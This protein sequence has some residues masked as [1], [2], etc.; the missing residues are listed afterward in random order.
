MQQ[1][2]SKSIVW[3]NP[4]GM[5]FSFSEP[6]FLSLLVVL[7]A[8]HR[9]L[10]AARGHSLYHRAYHT[11]RN[12]PHWGQ[13]SF[14]DAHGYW[15]AITHCCNC[16]WEGDGKAIAQCVSTVADKQRT[17]I[18]WHDIHQLLLG[19]KGQVIPTALK[20]WKLSEMSLQW[21]QMPLA[22]FTALKQEEFVIYSLDTWNRFF[23]CFA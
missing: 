12:C 9:A 21:E 2:F 10:L 4:R 17:N 19:G 14:V 6:A 23:L 18:D 13:Y 1:K 16:G 3:G 22:W 7:T 5:S 11:E 8:G 20:P 15:A